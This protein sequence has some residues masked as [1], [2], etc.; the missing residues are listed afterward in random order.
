VAP[1]EKFALGF[2]PDHDVRVQRTIESEDEVD[3]VDK[4]K[5]RTVSVSI[6][7]SNLGGEEKH[8]EIQERIPVSEIEHV[9]ITLVADKTSGA[10]DVNEHG[11]LSWKMPLPPLGRL[12]LQLV[13]VVATAP[14][15]QGL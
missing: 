10:P 12:R 11:V 15:V 7:L 13:Y 5:R 14:G 2:G 4:W 8:L 1:G 9:R 6:F 3:E